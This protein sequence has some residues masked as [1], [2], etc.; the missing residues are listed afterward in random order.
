M[1][2]QHT[3]LTTTAYT[4][5]QLPKSSLKEIPIFGRS[6]AGK[7]S[8]LNDLCQNKKLAKSSSTPGKTASI[9][10]FS[11]EDR[12]FLVDFPGYGYAKVNNTMSSLWK[13]NIA[14]YFKTARN[15][16][17]VLL[18]VDIRRTLKEEE[19]WI[20]EWA[21]RN[22]FPVL[23]IFSKADKIAKTKQQ[24]TCTPTI[25]QIKTHL[26]LCDISYMCYSTH[27]KQD[28]LLLAKQ[29]IEKLNGNSTS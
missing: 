23:M 10:F 24:R 27:H 28:K 5:A 9:N 13:K 15:I 6:N 2:F 1:N 8:L 29:I 18:L 25:E 12:C 21:A 4:P 17:F 22:K 7:S 16:A 26:P 19:W 20:L 3:R 11:V 14:L